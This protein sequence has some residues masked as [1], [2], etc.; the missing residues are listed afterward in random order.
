MNDAPPN[1]GLCALLDSL[2]IEGAA[3]DVFTSGFADVMDARVHVVELPAVQGLSHAK[4]ARLLYRHA[5][6]VGARWVPMWCIGAEHLDAAALQS[7]WW[8]AVRGG[9]VVVDAPL[10]AL[11][12]G[13]VAR[14][15]QGELLLLASAVGDHV[16]ELSA[17]TRALIARQD[18]LHSVTCDPDLTHVRRAILAHCHSKVPLHLTGEDGVG[19]VALA[20][21][22]HMSLDDR[23][24]MHVNRRGGVAR[25][26]QWALFEDVSLLAREQLECLSGCLGELDRDRPRAFFTP[27]RRERPSSPAFDQIVGGSSELV[28]LLAQL[29]LIAPSNLPV[30]FLGEPGVGKELMA[31]AVHAASGRRGPFVALDM[32]ALPEHLAEST[33]FGHRKG[34]FTGADYHREGA[35]RQAQGGTLFLDEIGNLALPLQ[36]KLLRALQEKQVV[37][38]GE[39]RPV[40]VD[41]RIV[42]ATNR[43]VE[44]MSR[45]GTFRLD[46]LTRLN[47]A[48]FHIPALRER[49][50]DLD[51]LAT[52]LLS[53]LGRAL[54]TPSW[55]SDEVREWMSTYHWPG[56]VRELSNVLQFAHAVAP[57]DAPILLEHLGGVARS[58]SRRAPVITTHSGEPVSASAIGLEEHQLRLMTL[59]TITVPALRERS[60]LARRQAI[61]DA[62]GGRPVHAGVL[63]LLEAHAWWG[64]FPELRASLAVLRALPPGLLDVETLQRELPGL[65]GP[66]GANKIKVLQAPNRDRSGQVFGSIWDID[67]AGVV[68][69]RIRAVEELRDAASAGDARSAVWIEQIERHCPASPE[70]LPFD[71]SRRLSRAH[72]LIA[73]EAGGLAVH[74]LPGTGLD[75][76]ASSLHKALEEVQVDVPVSVGGAGEVRVLY[77]DGRPYLQLFVFSGEVAYAEFA[78]LALASAESVRRGDQR[79][80]LETRG[81]ASA[82]RTDNGKIRVWELDEHE[83]EVLTDIVSSYLGGTFTQH[84]HNELASLDASPKYHKLVRYLSSAP[85]VPQYLLRLC[86]KAENGDVR[87]HIAR[88][89]SLMPDRDERLGMLPKGLVR[90]IEAEVQ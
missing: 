49:I 65:L 11:P 57:P 77:P 32:G 62:L 56:N 24:M 35:F 79:T 25:S 75:V 78:E 8:R 12:P 1:F 30:M 69:G 67:A 73:K 43:D 38:V 83:A 39:D 66:R 84:V 89:F 29:E 85:R 22:A 37:P 76:W 48:A 33:L 46:L 54:A 55:C 27:S 64:N 42:T 44:A 20:N 87:E 23:P 34:A 26:G 18:E 59:A 7:P 2:G 53:G 3:R 14:A 86:E 63:R 15:R 40:S 41:V 9:W 45:R 6:A 74:R 4:L 72:V 90:M 16:A 19:K 13:L 28:D 80:L 68:V 61:L 82:S 81:G 47:A 36:I 88:R 58:S 17:F 52:A 21:W 10:N 70:C 51:D 60:R 50:D 5:L 31:R 71:L